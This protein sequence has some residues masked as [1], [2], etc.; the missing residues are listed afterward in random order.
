MSVSNRA[1]RVALP[2]PTGCGLVQIEALGGNRP[3][4]IAQRSNSKEKVL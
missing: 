1:H 2:L 4:D 3:T